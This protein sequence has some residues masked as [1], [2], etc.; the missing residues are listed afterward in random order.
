MTDWKKDLLEILTN[1]FVAVIGAY[2]KILANNLGR[3]RSRAVL[4]ALFAGNTV[5]AGFCSLM[6]LKFGKIMH[7][8]PN[9]VSFMSGMS[10]WMGPSF[11]TVLEK[12]ALS[13][14]GGATDATPSD[15]G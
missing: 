13:K 10:G 4:I 3:R 5:I 15:N 14:L 11:L 7:W 8:D 9:W 6:V 1:G 12:Q 2:A